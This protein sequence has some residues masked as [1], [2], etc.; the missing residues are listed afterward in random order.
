MNNK[1]VTPIYFQFV[2]THFDIFFIQLQTNWNEEF[3]FNYRRISKPII[4]IFGPNMLV[5]LSKIGVA[6]L[7]EYIHEIESFGR[8]YEKS[9]SFFRFCPN[10]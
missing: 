4:T 1:I 2:L 9:S 6:G 3:V 8:K 7:P 10:F 5:I